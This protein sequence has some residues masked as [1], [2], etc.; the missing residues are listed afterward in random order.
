MQCGNLSTRSAKRDFKQ[1]GSWKSSM[2]SF[3]IR[4]SNLHFDVTEDDL[5]AEYSRCDGFKGCQIL[6][7]KQDRST[8]EALIEFDSYQ[9]LLAAQKIPSKLLHLIK[10][11]V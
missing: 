11:Q 4:A 6:W 3:Q 10:I 5:S 1:K 9:S 8:G 7:D 2:E